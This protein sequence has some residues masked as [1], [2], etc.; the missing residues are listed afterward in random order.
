MLHGIDLPWSHLTQAE[1]VTFLGIVLIPLWWLWGWSYLL[2]MLGLG[3]IAH[4]YLTHG[5]IKLKNPHPVVIFLLLH[6]LYG[7]ISKLFYGSFNPDAAFGVRDFTGTFN[8]IIGPAIVI[9]YIQSRRIWVRPQIIAWA[10]SVVVV[11]ML[12][13]WVGIYFGLHEA[14]Y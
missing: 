6:G 3:L 14:P 7:L 8:E 4:D 2:A 1:K 11:L 13:F 12:L 9:W 10:F 5:K